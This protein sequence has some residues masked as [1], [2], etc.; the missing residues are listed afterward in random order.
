MTGRLPPVSAICLTY[1]RVSILEEAIHSFLLQDYHGPKEL[2]VLNDLAS[3]TLRFEHPDVRVINLPLRFRTVGE[4]M[5]AAAALC[6]H[7]I[8]FVWDD[9]DIYLPNRISFS[10]QKLSETQGF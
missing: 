8:L 2:L 4:K 9:D 3:Q 5:N 1:G 10:I 6:S 7:D